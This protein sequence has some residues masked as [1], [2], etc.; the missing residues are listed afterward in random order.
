MAAGCA[1][2]LGILLLV[3]DLALLS[4]MV[5]DGVNGLSPLVIQ[6]NARRP[7]T[8]RATAVATRGTDMYPPQPIAIHYGSVYFP[9]RVL[10]DLSFS[11]DFRTNIG[12]ANLSD[13]VADFTMAL[14]RVEGAEDGRVPR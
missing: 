7:V 12:I 6:T 3:S 14:Q 5:S 10:H 11:D 8:V 13:K 4:Y 9:V 2:F 1:A